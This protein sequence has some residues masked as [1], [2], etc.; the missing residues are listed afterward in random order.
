M[1]TELPPNACKAVEVSTTLTEL[2][3]FAPWL[4]I[5]SA[6]GKSVYLVTGDTEEGAAVPAASRLVPPSALPF[7]IDVSPY[8]GQV[9]IA[10]SDDCTVVLE[11]RQ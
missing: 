4:I 9:F 6:E 7:P 3:L 11:G 1:A 10:A 2:K 8:E 5:W